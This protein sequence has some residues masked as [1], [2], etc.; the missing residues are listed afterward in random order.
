[1]EPSLDSFVPEIVAH[2]LEGEK[3]KQG[4]CRHPKIKEWLDEKGVLAHIIHG[5]NSSSTQESS[6][7]SIPGTDTHQR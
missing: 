4:K 7:G 3:Q 1:M 6:D 5:D 2:F